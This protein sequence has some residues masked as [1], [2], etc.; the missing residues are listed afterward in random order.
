MTRAEDVPH[1]GPETANTLTIRESAGP[2]KG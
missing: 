1:V 2:P